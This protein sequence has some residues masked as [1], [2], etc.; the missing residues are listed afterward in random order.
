VRSNG[1]LDPDVLSQIV[2]AVRQA[3]RNDE[4]GP[5]F[6]GPWIPPKAS[7]NGHNGYH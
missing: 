1:T 2:A 7:T 6:V 3:E 5:E 4:M